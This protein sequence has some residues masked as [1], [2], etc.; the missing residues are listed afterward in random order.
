MNGTDEIVSIEKLGTSWRG[1]FRTIAERAH[2][3]DNLT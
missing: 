3:Q 2:S 1:R